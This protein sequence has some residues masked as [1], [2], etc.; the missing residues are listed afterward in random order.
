MN[1]DPWRPTLGA[2][3]NVFCRKKTRFEAEP[4]PTW[5]TTCSLMDMSIAFG[6]PI[7]LVWLLLVRRGTW[8][9]HLA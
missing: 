7:F 6:R 2:L 5:N 1:G 8:A 3:V 4:P 9:G